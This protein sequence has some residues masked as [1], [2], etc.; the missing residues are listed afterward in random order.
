MVGIVL[1]VLVTTN[2]ETYSKLFYF[3]ERVYG[4]TR[5][6]LSLDVAGIHPHEIK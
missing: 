1:G 4:C 6:I 2:I 3:L 5:F